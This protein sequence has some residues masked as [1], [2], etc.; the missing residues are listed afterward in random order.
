MGVAK[1]DTRLT[2]AAA[3]MLGCRVRKKKRS[4]SVVALRKEAL[5]LCLGVEGLDVLA[6]VLITSLLSLLK[7]VNSSSTFLCT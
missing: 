1:S 2:G 3:G 6:N 5:V 4:T 7:L